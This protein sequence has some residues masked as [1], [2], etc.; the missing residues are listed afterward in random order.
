MKFHELENVEF[1]KCHQANI[2]TKEQHDKADNEP[3]G[4]LECMEMYCNLQDDLIQDFIDSNPKR[5]LVELM[6][7]SNY[8]NNGRLC[9]AI[10]SIPQ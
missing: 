8:E 4:C 5:E 6:E 9:F 3:E 7:Q 10:W 2:Q 1:V